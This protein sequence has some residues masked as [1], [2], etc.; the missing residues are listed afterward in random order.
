MRRIKLIMHLLIL[1]GSLSGVRAQWLP[2]PWTTMSLMSSLMDLGIELEDVDILELIETV[3]ENEPGDSIGNKYYYNQDLSMQFMLTMG[4]VLEKKA[5]YSKDEV[6]YPGSPWQSRF[7]A[8]VKGRNFC[9][10]SLAESDPGESMIP[11]TDHQTAGLEIEPIRQELKLVFGDYSL[12]HGLGLLFSTRLAFFG[13]NMDPHLLVF[14]AR[15]I[16]ANS[17]SNEDRF[18]R[19]GGIEWKKKGWKLTGFFSD[20]RIDA[21][22]DKGNLLKFQGSGYHR[23]KTE[24]ER[25]GQADEQAE[26]M[27]IEYRTDGMQVGGGCVELKYFEEK[28]FRL[29]GFTK[30]K[31]P[32]GM[33]FGEMSICDT[34]G[35]ATCLGLSY[36]GSDRH[37]FM[38]FFQNAGSAYF[39]RYTS[40]DGSDQLFTDKI[41]LR[42]NYQFHLRKKWILHSDWMIKESSW[43]RQGLTRP[44]QDYSFRLG[45]SKKQY[46]D[47]QTDF[48]ITLKGREMSALARYRKELDTGSLFLIYELGAASDL[49]I[50]P[51]EM[52]GYYVACDLGG[53]LT[54]I[55]LTYRTGVLI[56]SMGPDSPLMYR[57]EPDLYYQM[58]IPVLSGNGYR[59]YLCLRWRISEQLSFE[60][61]LNRYYY[62]D[63]SVLGSGAEKIDSPHRSLFRFQVLFRPGVS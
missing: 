2:D 14:R 11:F 32:G 18:L 3:V 43:W 5:G 48:R 50:K 58:S 22:V 35:L 53:K 55:D 63:R 40:L 59:A 46:D 26:G 36:F 49:S 4:R 7:R 19:G 56:H 62:L 41:C 44:I 27:L 54:N 37:R 57:Y 52:H 15:G 12:D 9:F 34:S 10:Y 1:I 25:V 16:K 28:V 8:A 45:L 29:G 6:V 42:V 24:I 61:K 17:T 20:K 38:F 47:Y 33:F 30:I 21:L 23:T 31:I 60:C 51:S 39:K 13:W